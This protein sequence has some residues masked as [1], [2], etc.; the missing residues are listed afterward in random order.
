MLGAGDSGLI[1]VP[2]DGL[3]EITIGVIWRRDAYLGRAARAFLEL[4]REKG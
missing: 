3:P 4:L 2:M 1:A